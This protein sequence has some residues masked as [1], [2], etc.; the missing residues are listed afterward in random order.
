[1][2]AHPYF[3]RSLGHFSVRLRRRIVPAT[4]VPV[5]HGAESFHVNTAVD[6]SR[7][8]CMESRGYPP[9]R[10]RKSLPASKSYQSPR[11]SQGTHGNDGGISERPKKSAQELFDFQRYHVERSPPPPCQTGSDLVSPVI[12]AL[13]GRQSFRCRMLPRLGLIASHQQSASITTSTGRC[14]HSRPTCCLQNARCPGTS[15]KPV[16]QR[17]AVWSGQV[18]VP[19]SK[20]MVMARPFFLFRP[21]GGIDPG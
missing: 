6:R 14:R 15:T 21:V 1:M 2:P 9:R 12:H 8:G 17:F 16:A 20:S 11:A 4:S 13:D 7:A 18:H 3:S 10:P 19:K 5:T